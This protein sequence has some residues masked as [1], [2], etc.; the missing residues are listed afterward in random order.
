MLK[1]LMTSPILQ[2]V[3]GRTLGGYA[4]VTGW[5][6][7]WT[8]IGRDKAEAAWASGQ[9]I[10]MTFWHGGLVFAHVGW[11]L[12]RRR[13]LR[14]LSSQSRDGGMSGQF[15]TSVSS[16]PIRG[17]SAHKGRQRG[18]AEAMLAMS[19]HLKSGGDIGFTPDGPRGPRMQAG[20]GV[21]Q[22]ARVSGAMIM[23]M[24]WSATASMRLKSWDRLMLLLPFGRGFYVYGDPIT[25]PRS[26][27]ASAMEA[28]RAHLEAELVRLSHEADRAAGREPVE[29]APREP[30]I[31]AA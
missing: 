17:S 27:D 5:L 28:A 22:L 30:A 9:P 1:S 29:P 23:P 24:A 16:P 13:R 18:G 15:A 6:T 3:L 19:K 8:W 2:V 12:K 26:A 11:P 25:V 14:M 4:L 31:T 20:L 7:R 21:I 10:I